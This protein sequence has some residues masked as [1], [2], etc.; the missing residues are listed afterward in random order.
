MNNWRKISSLKTTEFSGCGVTKAP[1]I[2]IKDDKASGCLALMLCIKQDPIS[3]HIRAHCPDLTPLDFQMGSVRPR[4]CARVFVF[5]KAHVSRSSLS[6]PVSHEGG[7]VCHTSRPAL[8]DV[9]L[10]SPCVT[11]RSEM[12]LATTALC[13]L[14]C[15][16]SSGVCRA[17]T[18]PLKIIM[19]LGYRGGKKKFQGKANVVF[20]L[21][22]HEPKA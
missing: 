16:R 12:P 22:A 7:G 21:F 13:R 6:V 17:L 20:H 18:E 3:W 15:L 2:F 8:R 1:G 14:V 19:K 4:P 11:L 5:C 9:R 10:L